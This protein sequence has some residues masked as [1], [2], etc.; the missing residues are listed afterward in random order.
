MLSVIFLLFAHFQAPPV[1]IKQRASDSPGDG[2]SLF[3][4]FQSIVFESMKTYEDE[5][6]DGMMVSGLFL[7]AV[8][9]HN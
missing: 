4:D 9:Q 3:T 2:V 5:G 7:D 8:S 1:L 6:V